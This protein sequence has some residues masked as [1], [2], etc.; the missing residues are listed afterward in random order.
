M[1]TLRLILVLVAAA[2]VFSIP[3]SGS[4]LPFGTD[5]ETNLARLRELHTTDPEQYARLVHNFDRFRTLAPEIQTKI[6]ELDRQLNDQD[7]Q[8]EARL[9]SVLG[10]YASWLTRLPDE[11]RQRVLA[12]ASNGERIR[13]IRE[14]KERQWFQQLPAIY[15]NQYQAASDAEKTRLLERWKQEEQKRREERTETRRWE[16]LA[17]ERPMLNMRDPRFQTELTNFVTNRLV[18][19]LSPEERR[20]LQEDTSKRSPMDGVMGWMRAVAEL[21]EKH[22]VL[23]IEAKYTRRAELPEEYER[24]LKSMPTDLVARLP[25][26]RWP[27]YPLAV[28]KLFRNRSIPVVKQLGPAAAAEIS[29]AVAQFLKNQLWPE[30]SERE[31][32]RLTGAEKR[33][34]DY[35]ETLLSLSRDHKLAVP[36]IGLPGEPRMWEII[37]APRLKEPPERM[38]HDFLEEYYLDNPNS[39]RLRPNDT[40]SREFFKRQFYAKY[41]HM[42]QRPESKGPP[43]PD[44]RRPKKP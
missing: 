36:D 15:R 28:T 23:A 20:G 37:R 14:I 29:P 11:E 24:A 5:V 33:W 6:R 21:S 17:Q 12:A 39:P 2:V 30:L 27:D 44:F 43:D 38:F 8:T 35:P 9:M 25:D 40:M 13:V 18:P 10:E 7:P 42:L 19:L 34:P 16:I 1:R 41:P 4:S 3:G 32:Q 26:G 31:R 22:P